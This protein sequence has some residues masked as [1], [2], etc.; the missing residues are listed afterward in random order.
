MPADQRY[1]VAA[2]LP[3]VPNPAAFEA[4]LEKLGIIA[5]RRSV[6]AHI[7]VAA[8]RRKLGL[9]QEE[10]ALRF[11]LDVATVRNWEQGRYQPDGAARV[12]LRVIE[13][14]PAAV[15]GALVEV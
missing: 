12:L 14:H 3:D 1:G 6:P 2:R 9:S 15:E 10:F 7:D 5:E 13:R 11:G 8:I 4:D